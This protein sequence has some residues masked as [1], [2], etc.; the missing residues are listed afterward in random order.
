MGTITNQ[1]PRNRFLTDGIHLE[2]EIEHLQKLSVK[3]GV[4]LRDV[5]EIV[6]LLERCRT[7]DLKHADG[8][9]KDEQI[10]GAAELVERLI[11][12]LEDKS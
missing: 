3:H 11:G 7:N 5:I 2:E 9:A 4:R 1:L 10:S 8:D 6:N 12:V